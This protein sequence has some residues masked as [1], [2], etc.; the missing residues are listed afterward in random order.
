MSHGFEGPLDDQPPAAGWTGS[1][2]G[3]GQVIVVAFAADVFSARW[4]GP[5]QVPD[6]CNIGSTVAI[7]KKAVVADAVLAF[8]QD[9]DQESSDEL[10]C[11]QRHGGVS[12]GA[13]QA[14]VLH[15]EGHAG[16]VEADQ[17]AV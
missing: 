12:F 8:G 11:A 7:S 13:I 15:L 9:M 5:E 3:S 10:G 6:P 4:F 17:P 2:D 14:V 1:C 16:R